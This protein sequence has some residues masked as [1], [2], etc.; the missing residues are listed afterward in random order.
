MRGGIAILTSLFPPSVGGIQTQ[1]L[2]LARALARLGADVHVVTRP[3][4]GRPAREQIDGVLVHRTGYVAGAARLVASLGTTVRVVHAQQMLSP[5]SAAV[6][7]H[8]GRGLP[9]VVTVHAS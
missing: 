3:A 2:A 4:R 1:T 5:A 7:L 6:A 8:A 9:F